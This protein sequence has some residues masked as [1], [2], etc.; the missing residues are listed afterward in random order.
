MSF[1]WCTRGKI[2]ME[3]FRL[4]A[5]DRGTFFSIESAGRTIYT[6]PAHPLIF[7]RARL[8]L[9]LFL[10]SRLVSRSTNWDQSIFA[11]SK[12]GNQMS[13][14]PGIRGKLG[15]NRRSSN[16][17]LIGFHLD[18]CHWSGLGLRILESILSRL[19]LIYILLMM[20]CTI[21]WKNY[22]YFVCWRIYRATQKY[23]T[24][25]LLYI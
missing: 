2:L 25:V 10:I 7:F 22:Y 16:M 19:R 21:I 11:N 6:L 20:W 15:L 3:R 23:I 24:T 5:G 17:F 8:S 12:Y 1:S 13:Q 4:S 9:S 14:F 18:T